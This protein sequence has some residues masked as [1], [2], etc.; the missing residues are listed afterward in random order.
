LTHPTVNIKLWGE[1]IRR[2]TMVSSKKQYELIVKCKKCDY[3]KTKKVD[4]EPENLMSAKLHFT[5][6]VASTHTKHPDLNNFDISH[7][8]D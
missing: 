2:E 3:Q 4:V 6:E 8:G 1:H 7:K 5:K